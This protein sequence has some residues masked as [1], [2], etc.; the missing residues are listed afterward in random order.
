MAAFTGRGSR[1][2]HSFSQ[3]VLLRERLVDQLQESQ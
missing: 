3:L 2:V 1:V